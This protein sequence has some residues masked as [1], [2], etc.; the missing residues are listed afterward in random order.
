VKSEVLPEFIWWYLNSEASKVQWRLNSTSTTG[1][2]NLNAAII[3]NLRVPVP[4]MKIQQEISSTLKVIVEEIDY[5]ISKS[6]KSIDV[7]KERRQSL[8][9]GAVTG[10]IDVRKVA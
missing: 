4:P 3:N 1:L 7:L 10:K 5:L 6:E 8:I 2:G 9:S